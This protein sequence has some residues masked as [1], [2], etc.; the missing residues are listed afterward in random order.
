MHLTEAAGPG[1]KILCKCK[2]LPSIHKAKAEHRRFSEILQR[3]D[4]ETLWLGD[5][6]RLSLDAIYV[7][8]SAAVESETRTLKRIKC[9]ATVATTRFS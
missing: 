2:H 3:Y 8:D 6:E 5:D 7:R 1:G 9:V 4:V